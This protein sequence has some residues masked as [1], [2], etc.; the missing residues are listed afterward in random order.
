MNQSFAFEGILTDL[1]STV[2][3]IIPKFSNWTV[4]NVLINCVACIYIYMYMCTYIMLSYVYKC[5]V[6]FS[7]LSNEW[8][9]SLSLSLI[10]R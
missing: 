1:H 3:L 4:L 10:M 5:Y 7:G 6:V 9:K 8:W 2:Y